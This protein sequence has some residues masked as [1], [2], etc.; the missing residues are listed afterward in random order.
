MNTCNHPIKLKTIK[1][2]SWEWMIEL[3]W[4]RTAWPLHC[5]QPLFQCHPCSKLD[6]RVLCGVLNACFTQISAWK[7]SSCTYNLFTFHVP[8]VL[9]LYDLWSR[10]NACMKSWRKQGDLV[11]GYTDCDMYRPSYL[12]GPDSENSEEPWWRLGNHW[13][14]HVSQELYALGLISP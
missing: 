12:H 5:S 7:I 6:Y 4:C 3:R 13:L 11:P 8:D 1:I 14:R 10:L 9:C 2:N